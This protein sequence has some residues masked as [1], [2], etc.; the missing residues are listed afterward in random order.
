MTYLLGAAGI[1]WA[2]LNIAWTYI[3]HRESLNDSVIKWVHVSGYGIVGMI[4][5]N[6]SDIFE[7]SNMILKFLSSLFGAVIVAFGAWKAYKETFKNIKNS[8]E[9]DK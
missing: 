3:F 2:V 4:A 1:I 8:T 7:V 9:N 5:P 6:I